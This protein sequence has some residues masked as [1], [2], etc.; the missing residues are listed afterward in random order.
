[1]VIGSD[2]S[3]LGLLVSELLSGCDPMLQV[4]TRLWQAAPQSRIEGI[5]N[6]AA[7]VHYARR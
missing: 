2:G 3:G 1:M 4:E 7:R 5:P 6:E